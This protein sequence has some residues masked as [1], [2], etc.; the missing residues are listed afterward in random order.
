MKTILVTLLV[1]GLNSWC[2][3]SFAQSGA[4][5]PA[6]QREG[7]AAPS[8][9]GS[10]DSAAQTGGSESGSSK[11]GIS[12]QELPVTE[13][14][15]F[16]GR[17][18]KLNVM[19]DPKITSGVGPD[20]KPM[21]VPMMQAQRFDNV[22]ALDA[23]N[24]VVNNYGFVM[25]VNPTNNFVRI[26]SKDTQGPEPKVTE[27]FAIRYGAQYSTNVNAITN[28]ST[29]IEKSFPNS[30]AYADIRTSQLVINATEKEMTLIT[31]L[32]ARLDVPVHQILI[33]ARFV[34]TT[35]NPQTIKCVDWT[36]TLSAQN[37]TWGNG[38]TVGTSA[39]REP[40]AS[41]T[42]TTPGGRPLAGA[43]GSVTET[44][45]RTTIGDTT[46]PGINANTAGG[47]MP[48]TF[49]LNAD[50]VKVVLSFLNSDT[51]SD[52][53]ATPRAIA[54][55]GQ[56]TELSDIQNIPVFEQQ[57]G[58]IAAGT[59]QPNTV[60]PN[61][62]L[63]VGQYTLNEV[64]TKLIVTPRVAGETNVFMVLQPELSAQGPTATARLS[65]QVNEAPTFVRKKITTQAIVPS[66]YTLV[67]GGLIADASAKSHTKVPI[68]GDIPI[69]GLAFRK[70]AKSRNK[71][72][73]IIFVTPTIIEQGD[74]QAADNSREF[75][76]SKPLEKPDEEWSAWDSAKPHDWTKPVE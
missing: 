54:L 31:N 29:L 15:M 66:G 36:P 33:E 2:L 11:E 68:L 49:F 25:I 30:R 45:L 44:L 5:T 42:G 21:P 9:G 71:R 17:S 18:A 7:G 16:L 37:I 67:L 8:A 22:S 35:R 53:L 76:K 28:L 43:S 69:L 74:F 14:L 58:N 23:L 60:K 48:N 47:F 63:K 39:T 72:N 62:D 20:G 56:P 3:M 6:A 10:S 57:Q 26:T 52:L 75:L 19:I 65:G 50:G 13:A 27:I 41:T 55:E 24:A 61:Y 12:I 40:G 46:V 59:T 51:E 70:D 1:M 32:L 4:G 34:E 38:L 64:G 73:L